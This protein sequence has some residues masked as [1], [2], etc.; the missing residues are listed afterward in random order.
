MIQ[1]ANMNLINLGAIFG[2][3]DL[4]LPN[5]LAS[6]FTIFCVVGITNAFNW[7]DGIDGFFFISGSISLNRIS[8]N[9]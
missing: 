7:I 2:E 5:Y 8:H 1:L 9:W 3:S 6:L 4:I